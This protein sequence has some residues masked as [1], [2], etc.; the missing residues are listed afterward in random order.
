LQ[1][2]APATAMRRI[3]LTFGVV[4]VAIVAK[5]PE[6]V[7]PIG[8]DTGMFAT[9]GR[10]LLHGARPYLDFWD[11]H[12]PLVY[13]YWAAVQ[14][15]AGA[16][17]VRA[18]ALAHLLDG[19]VSLAVAGFAAAIAR[20]LGSSTGVAALAAVLTVA[21]ANL[22][23]FS[24]EGSSPTKLALLPGVVAVWAYVGAYDA[25]PNAWRWALLAGAAGGAATLGKQP[26]VLVLVALLGHAAWQRGH[27]GWTNLL[28][29]LAGAALALGLSL[30]YLGW[31]GVLG[32]FVDQVF[33]YNLERVLLGYWHSAQGM[34]APAIRL[35]LVVREAAAVLFVMAGVGALAVAF[36]PDRH[37]Q[38]V[39]LWWA[40]ASTV[41]IAGF[42]EFEQIV[43][44]FAILAAVGVERFWRA[45][46]RDGLELGHPAVGRLALVGFL[47][48]VL[49]LSSGFQVTE[50]QRAWFERGPGS[51]PAL[52]E[53]LALRLRQEVPAGPLFVWGNAGQLYE[54]SGRDPAS[55]FL[56]GEALRATAP[57]SAASRAQLLADLSANPPAAIVLAPHVDQPD[58]RLADF[59]DLDAFIRGC[60][61]AAGMTADMARDWS[62]YVRSADSANCRLAGPAKLLARR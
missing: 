7:L 51:A 48:T 44:C 9:Y 50:M 32:A 61:V 5:L 37:V 42:R 24:Q 22:S 52:S 12:P 62:L 39:L 15:L 46:G 33:T 28:A 49:A 60:Y 30:A 54:L 36:K 57:N 59:P 40:A 13:V 10:L 6:A 2:A 25:S 47:G 3:A 41:S 14:V 34:R 29:L 38:R 11:V 1:P 56:N 55:R 58:L 27:R 21:F 18:I 16:D 45:A 4:L 53:L 20:R 23:M 8:S 43:P 26:A 17:R 31:L 35:D 19:A